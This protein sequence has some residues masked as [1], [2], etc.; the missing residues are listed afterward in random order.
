MNEDLSR[1]AAAAARYA[2]DDE[3]VAAVVASDAGYVCAFNGSSRSWLVLDER[4]EPIVLR[5]RVL[6]VVSLA[7][8]REVAEEVGGGS[9]VGS[10]LEIGRG[11]VEGLAREVES[12]YKLPLRD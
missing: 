6:E 10:A 2:E 1:I 9:D 3:V 5:A 7:V 11:A 4:G 8:A 12:R